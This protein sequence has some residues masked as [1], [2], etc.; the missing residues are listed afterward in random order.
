L[1]SAKVLRAGM[2]AQFALNLF[3]H[4]DDAMLDALRTPWLGTSSRASER[5]GDAALPSPCTWVIGHEGQGMS[6]AL[7][8]RCARVLRIAQ[9]GGEESLNAAVAAGICMHESV[10]QRPT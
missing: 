10:R 3:E 8:A 9:P 6:S 2:G 1:W 4:A 7:E 5:L